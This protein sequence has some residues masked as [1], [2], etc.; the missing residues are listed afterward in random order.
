MAVLA[1]DPRPGQRILDV[2]AAPGGKSFAAAIHT[3][4]RAE[5]TACDLHPNK[6]RRIRDGAAR[7]GIECI[8]TLARDARQPKPGWD[9]FFDLV[10]TDVPCSGLGVI[11]KK[12]EIRWKDPDGLAGL[13]EVQYA[14]L[15][16]ASAS[17]APGGTLL[18]STCTV[19]EAENAAVVRR[20]LAEHAE[21]SPEDFT[22]LN[23]AESDQGMLQLWPQR[24]GT[25]GFFIAKLRKLH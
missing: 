14:I 11:R 20:F 3:E 24:H 12:P 2:C 19:R 13:P 23:G 25:D 10:L 17:V 1:A 18:Y 8:A 7:L 22:C 4:G 5:I 6:L 21:F 15:C 16:G 9:N